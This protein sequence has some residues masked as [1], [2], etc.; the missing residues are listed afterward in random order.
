M[1]LKKTSNFINLWLF[2]RPFW[3]NEQKWAQPGF[4]PGTSR[5]QSENHT[6]RPLSLVHPNQDRNPCLIPFVLCNEVMSYGN[7]VILLRLPSLIC[8]FRID[9]DVLFFIFKGTPSTDL[10]PVQKTKVSS[11]L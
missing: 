11:S 3:T 5:T 4:E 7:Y 8:R 9:L 6:P 2:I 10:A 1:L